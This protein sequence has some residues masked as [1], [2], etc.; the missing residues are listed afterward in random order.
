MPCPYN[1]AKQAFSVAP[2]PLVPLVSG[3]G[4]RLK[5]LTES[6]ELHEISYCEAAEYGSGTV[7]PANRRNQDGLSAYPVQLLGI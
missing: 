3:T 7:A 5:T 2:A 4:E 6:A 1:P